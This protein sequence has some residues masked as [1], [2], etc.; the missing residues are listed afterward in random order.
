[1]FFPQKTNRTNSRSLTQKPFCK[2]SLC[3][4]SLM[5]DK[6][7]KLGVR[8]VGSFVLQETRVT[9]VWDRAAPPGWEG[10]E[11]GGGWP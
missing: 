6:Q 3:S 8:F 1:M 9:S 5:I 10:G 7:L 11:G 4:E 2:A